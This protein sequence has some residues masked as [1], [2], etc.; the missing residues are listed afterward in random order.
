MG[1]VRVFFCFRILLSCK[2]LSSNIRQRTMKERNLLAFFF[3]FI[4]L[5]PYPSFPI[6]NTSGLQGGHIISIFVILLAFTSRGRITINTGALIY[7]TLVTPLALT[8]I[9]LDRSSINFNAT[10]AQCIG[11][12]VI[13]AAYTICRTD[14][15]LEQVLNGSALAVIFH[16]LIGLIQQFYYSR[17]DFPFSWI[18]INPSFSTML[19]EE[20]S[21]LYGTYTKRSFGI[22]PEPS[23]MFASISPWLVIYATRLST[24]PCPD[25]TE[26]RTLQLTA[27]FLGTV[28]VSLSKSGG[29]VYY[30]ALVLPFIYIYSRRQIL[31]QSATGIIYTGLLVILS[32]IASI[33]LIGS[34]LDRQTAQANAVGSWEE[35][36]SSI[37][38][39]ID[40]FINGD[41]LNFIL[42]HG[43]GNIPEITSSAVGSTSIHSWIVAYI[44][45]S[46]LMALIAVAALG[47]TFLL[48]ILIS[49]SNWR[50]ISAAGMVLVTLSLST[51]YFQL[52]GIWMFIG[53]LAFILDNH[54]S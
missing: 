39:G 8:L 46:G 30:T 54:R 45:G 26:K 2:E 48:K 35:R 41:S 23:A 18:Y 25:P 12:L 38:F 19:Y 47:F 9:I 37:R 15:G 22:F 4:C 36:E 51:G 13:P 34:Y 14:R 52:L 11:L 17:N 29:I 21:L 16:S 3:G 6:G 28:L 50:Y 44:A 1:P 10:I 31:K 5:L 42:G 24:I 7:F 40:L 20:L 49:R 27:L 33:W 32:I 43:P 53:L